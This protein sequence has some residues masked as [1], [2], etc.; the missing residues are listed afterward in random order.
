MHVFKLYVDIKKPE[1][2]ITALGRTG[3]NVGWCRAFPRIRALPAPKIE[4]V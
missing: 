4:L 2:S 3:V 1:S